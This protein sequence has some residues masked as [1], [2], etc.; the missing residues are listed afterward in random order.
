[1]E[2]QKWLKMSPN[3]PK[4]EKSDF[5]QNGHF[6]AIFCDFGRFLRQKSKFGG[7]SPLQKMVLWPPEC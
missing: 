5:G 2:L 1:M 3:G 6:R 4:I 7:K